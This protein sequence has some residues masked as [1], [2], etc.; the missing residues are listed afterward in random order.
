M[1]IFLEA[2]AAVATACALFYFIRYTAA[3]ILLNWT[4]YFLE[5]HTRYKKPDVRKF[6]RELMEEQDQEEEY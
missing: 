5:S 2:W 4:V 3:H 6:V 1:M